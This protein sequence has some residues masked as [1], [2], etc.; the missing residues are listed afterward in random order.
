MFSWR[1]HDYLDGTTAYQ[2]IGPDGTLR[3]AFDSAR[4]AARFA[5]EHNDRR[6]IR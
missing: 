2:V 6:R 3:Q 4:Q 5:R 1:I